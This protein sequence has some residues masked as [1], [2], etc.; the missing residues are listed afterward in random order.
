MN[1]G[2]RCRMRPLQMKP[3]VHTA[4]QVTMLSRKH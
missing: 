3:R 2:L 1:D 4:R